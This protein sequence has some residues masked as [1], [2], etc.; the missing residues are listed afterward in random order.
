MFNKSASLFCGMLL[1]ACSAYAPNNATVT[2]DYFGV[3]ES[4]AGPGWNNPLNVERLYLAEVKPLVVIFGTVGQDET[5][6]LLSNIIIS[7]W[8]DKVWVLDKKNPVSQL[9]QTL[10]DANVSDRPVLVYQNDNTKHILVGLPNI[11]KFF[12][13][14]GFALLD[15]N[16]TQYY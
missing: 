16:N 8:K 12:E 1:L 9:V 4:T 13:A 10:M 3:R 6:V 7:G 2:V 15:I 14:H 11:I 5:E